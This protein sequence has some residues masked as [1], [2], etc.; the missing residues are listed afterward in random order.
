MTS[1]ET[2]HALLEDLIQ[3]L[4]GEREIFK[5]TQRSPDKGL[6][7]FYIR[8]SAKVAGRV[9]G[10]E[11][12]HLRALQLVVDLMGRPEIWNLEFVK[13]S[14]KYRER[15]KNTPAPS[16]H[17][18]SGAE[19]LL[20]DLLKQLKIDASVTASGSPEKGYIFAI[21]PHEQAALAALLDYHE[22]VYYGTKD[23][24]PLNLVGAL[25][26]IFRGIGKNSGVSYVL[27]VV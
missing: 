23:T 25:G 24:S 15:P 20:A 19:A 6:I 22:A 17:S 3:S 13:P 10:Y 27:D 9:I 8:P 16:N 18:T 5:L 12:C 1:L 2:T 4:V 7:N 11:G 14:D 26:T 21:R